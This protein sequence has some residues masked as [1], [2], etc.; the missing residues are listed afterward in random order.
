MIFSIVTFCIGIL[1]LLFSTKHFIKL[2]EKASSTLRLSPLII[3]ATLVSI[4]TS[5]P[6]LA[7][8]VTALFKHDVGLASGNIIGSNIVNVFL[9]LGVGIVSGKLKVGTLKTQK[10]ALLMLLSAGIFLFLYFS[11]ISARTAGVVL[12]TTAFAVTV[13]EYL[14]GVNGRNHEDASWNHRKRVSKISMSDL[15]K[16]GAA[17]V[18]VV[19]GGLLTVT[20]IESL[21]V[22]LGLSTTILG[23]TITAVAT[24]LPELF[25]TIFS[26]KDHEDKI[27]I[28]NLLGS[29]IY[30]L[31]LIGG[32]ILFFS[33]WQTVTRY[34]ILMLTI[35]T[36]SFTSVVFFYK[37]SYIPRKVG[38]LLLTL[39]AVYIYLL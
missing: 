16:L 32:I 36:L 11:Q 1:F 21:A 25:T 15:P 9:V 7:V 4:G 5:L 12:L 23:L 29:N 17:L 39:F 38:F 37:G 27:A 24:S 3:G 6:E 8:S 10:N 13:M 31:T 35:A 30:N 2:S 14:W 28:G 34:E 26:E 33:S 20:S 18:G 19:A 22:I